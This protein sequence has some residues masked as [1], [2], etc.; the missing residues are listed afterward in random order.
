ME[1]Q[2]VRILNSI[3]DQT[4]KINE[5][6]VLIEKILIKKINCVEHKKT[7][8]DNVFNESLNNFNLI[9]KINCNSN[10]ICENKLNIKELNKINESE[11]T[12]EK[13]N[14]VVLHKAGLL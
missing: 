6:L 10:P 5:T 9:T 8:L 4:N 11:I 7:Q 13:E 12:E 14:L 2:N 1:K 3:I